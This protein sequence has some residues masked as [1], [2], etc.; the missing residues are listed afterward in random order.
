MTQEAE[1]QLQSTAGIKLFIKLADEWELSK[2]DQLALL[3]D[4]DLSRLSDIRE[5]P[6]QALLSEDQLERIGLIFN[7]HANL[8][9]MFDKLNQSLFLTNIQDADGDFPGKSPLSV[10]TSGI[11]GMIKVNNYLESLR[12]G[13]FS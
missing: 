13:G 12:E 6:D 3:G 1:Q 7:I 9:A 11:D 5:H 4:M 2:Q 8:S 10:M